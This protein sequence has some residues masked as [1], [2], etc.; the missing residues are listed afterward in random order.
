MKET[1]WD[2][3][4]LLFSVTKLKTFGISRLVSV[5]LNSPTWINFYSAGI[6]SDWN[7][8]KSNTRS[9]KNIENY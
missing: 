2:Y 7:E 9:L 8:L 5:T 3:I 1:A 6:E 4:L